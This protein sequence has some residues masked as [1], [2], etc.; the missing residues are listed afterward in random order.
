M[1]DIIR[2]QEELRKMLRE[3]R[4]NAESSNLMQSIEG[5][6][7][8]G[9]AYSAGSKLCL[10]IDRDPLIS[11]PEEWLETVHDRSRLVSISLIELANSDGKMRRIFGGV[12]CLD[13]WY[14]T[15]E[16]VLYG[17]R[18]KRR[19]SVGHLMT[20]MFYDY[21]EYGSFW[22]DF[23][24]WLAPGVRQPMIMGS[25][26]TYP[27]E[28]DSRAWLDVSPTVLTNGQLEWWHEYVR[29]RYQA[30]L[31]EHYIRP[32]DNEHISLYQ[33]IHHSETAY[34]LLVDKLITSRHLLLMNENACLTAYSKRI[35][36][37]IASDT[38]RIV[39]SKI[40]F[41]GNEMCI[42]HSMN[43]LVNYAL[44]S[45]ELS[46]I[47]GTHDP[48]LKIIRPTVLRILEPCEIRN[49]ISTV[50]TY[51]FRRRETAFKEAAEL[52][53]KLKFGEIDL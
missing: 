51:E 10:A 7:V 6:D 21:A 49:L 28:L 22:K 33:Q 13:P 35:A 25:H 40:T 14:T 24:D 5:G 15:I 41:T 23:L 34:E 1:G 11:Y 39:P 44:Y 19:V 18:H 53:K 30:K 4:E 50:H 8:S 12:M 43:S 26:I 46:S 32:D 2:S 47:I 31:L 52:R 45:A 37:I 48:I 3:C 38:M 17:I 9:R 42:N 29:L 16:I 36:D 20:E 27:Y